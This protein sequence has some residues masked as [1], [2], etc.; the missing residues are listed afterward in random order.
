MSEPTARARERERDSPFAVPLL[1]H[2]LGGLVHRWPG[3]WLWLS[4]VESNG[5]ERE[6]AGLSI[7]K[8]I[9]VCGLARSGSTLLHEIISSC[10]SVATQRVK[11][12]PMVFTPF[13]WRRALAGQHPAA[14]RE[15]AHRDGMMITTDS[16]DA[17]EEMLWMAFFPRCHDPSVSN[18]V[19]ADDHY[20]AFESF[21][22]THIRKLLL[23]EQA[24]RYAAKANYHIARLAY[25]A[26]LFPDARFVI[27]IRAPAGHITS[28]MRQHQWFSQGQRQEPRARAYMQRSGH[29]EFGLDRRPMHLGDGGRVRRIMAAWSAGDEVRGLAQYWAM[30][31]EYLARLLASNTQVRQAAHV[32]RFETLCADP[33]GTLR[34]VLDHCELP[35]ADRIIERSAPNIR[36]PTYY[37]STLSPDDQEVI[38]QETG[39][40]ARPW[41]Y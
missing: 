2:V 30:V 15:R 17:L 36:Y 29:F 3:L 38:H 27:P 28:L 18:L 21:Y 33:A 34:G 26:R 31:H 23:A 25:L 12:Y 40:A 39:V 6:I 13:W 20:P 10:R 5:L 19:G 14:P 8:P 41:G 37:T 9:Y 1:L 35:D 24:T 4:R 22:R 32:V 7:R 11:D 16:P